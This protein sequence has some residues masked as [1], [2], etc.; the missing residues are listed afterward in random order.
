ME[1]RTVS[2]L[3]EFVRIFQLP[4]AMI[5]HI[6]FV[7]TEQEIDLV[8]GLNGNVMT[9]PQ[10]AEMLAMPHAEAE[11][12]LQ[13]AYYRQIV[14]R[15]T[16][17][18]VTTYSAHTFYR[19]LNPLSM[20]ENWGDVPAD[21]RDAVIEWQL[22]EFINI[23]LPVVEELRKNPD[24]YVR[25]P[26]RDVLLLDEAL[27]MVDAATE[28][29]V[30]PCDCRAIVMAC[31]RPL[32]A[33]IRLDEGARRTL[34]MGHGR[35]LSRDEMKRLVV[36]ADRAGLMHTGNRRWRQQGQLFGFCNCCACDCYP[37]RGGIKLGMS[38]QWPRA[39]HIA[40][41]DLTRCHMCGKCAQRCHFGAFFRDGTRV[42]V[43]DKKMRHVAFDPARCWD[44]GL[45]ATG[46]PEGAIAMQPLPVSAAIDAASGAAETVVLSDQIRRMYDGYVE[47]RRK[48][49]T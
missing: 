19:R 13:Q 31:D 4:P 26:N 22:Q 15:K 30:V 25:I 35:R 24:A 41:R 43:N 10:V 18:G 21:A 33:C 46:C 39:H 17:D 3:D 6:A 37:F 48:S 38:Q 20:Y 11:A 5:P 2:K 34:E 9:L 44:C 32:E 14:K 49:H 40:E 27:E 42:V 29:V 12:F 28:H 23:W 8:V 16:E 45:C 7:A 36:D 1:K 47:D